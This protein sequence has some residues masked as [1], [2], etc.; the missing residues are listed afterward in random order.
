[1]CAISHRCAKRKMNWGLSSGGLT[2]A[3]S[4]DEFIEWLDR[5]L[6]PFRREASG[7]IYFDSWCSGKLS[8]SAFTC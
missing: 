8:T 7:S 2:M 4:G 3:L 6:E 1:M 5:E